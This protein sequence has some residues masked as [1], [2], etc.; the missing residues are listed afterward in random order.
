M[1]VSDKNDLIDV[2]SRTQ[3]AL[4]RLVVNET[5]E[6]LRHKP[7]PDKWCALEILCHLRDCEKPAL[8]E[9]LRRIL[10]EDNPTL[11]YVDQDALYAAGD[12]MNQ[13]PLKAWKRFS[14]LRKQTLQV[15]HNAHIDEWDRPYIH[16][17]RGPETFGN[18]VRYFAQHDKNHLKQI[19]A[20]IADY[21]A[22][23]PTAAAS[24][25]P[26]DPRVKK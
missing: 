24:P 8:L 16:P 18:L 6:S 3:D 25:P 26:P 11:P 23:H 13:D 12:Y 19:R 9:R 20:A 1:N 15:L 14:V 17:T 21:L 2:L 7:A 22:K 4:E 5:P 10:K